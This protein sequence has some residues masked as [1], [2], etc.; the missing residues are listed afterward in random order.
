MTSA[1]GKI[2]TGSTTINLASLKE[3]ETTIATT[4]S[5]D[6]CPDKSANITYTASLEFI[7][8]TTRPASQDKL[9]GSSTLLEVSACNYPSSS[10]RLRSANNSPSARCC[11]SNNKLSVSN[12]QIPQ[13][14]NS[15]HSSWIAPPRRNLGDSNLEEKRS[16]V[17]EDDD[18]DLMRRVV[19][20]EKMKTSQMREASRLQK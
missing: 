14:C 2:P 17:L 8:P 12:R 1:N 3:G 9:I 10:M 15:N 18:H 5:I 11:V 16:I 19:D 7:R 13:R 4:S 20:Q 6:K